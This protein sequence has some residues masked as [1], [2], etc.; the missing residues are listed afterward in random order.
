MG[1]SWATWSAETKQE[2][3]RWLAFVVL[4]QHVET[5]A[6]YLG[7]FEKMDFTLEDYVQADEQTRRMKLESAAK[8]K[9][10]I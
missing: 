2:R 5:Y 1:W 3:A 6:S 8:M 4:Q 9:A 7:A 10:D